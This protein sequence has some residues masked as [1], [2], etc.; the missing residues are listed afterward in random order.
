M[1]ETVKQYIEHQREHHR[2]KSFEEEYL[3]ALRNHR[4]EYDPRYV[5]EAEHLG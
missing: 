3:T 5:F 1:S 4:I 2:K